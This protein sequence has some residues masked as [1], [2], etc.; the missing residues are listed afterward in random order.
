LD[1]GRGGPFVSAGMAPAVDRPAPPRLEMGR[2]PV[3]KS[4]E[5]TNPESCMSRARPEEMTF[6]LLARD[7]AAPATIRAWVGE[8][9]RLGK[10]VLGDKQILEALDCAERME[11]QR[12]K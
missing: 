1:H 4:E 7:V 6:V 2:C 3:I 12:A 10:N 8:R 9:L 11:A 5:L